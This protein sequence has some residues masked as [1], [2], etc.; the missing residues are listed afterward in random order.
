MNIH[1]ARENI[2]YVN[3]CNSFSSYF[4]STIFLELT[5]GVS[6]YFPASLVLQGSPDHEGKNHNAS[7]G[8]HLS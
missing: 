1:I 2:N 3:S 8:V 7:R 5:S 4:L 6:R